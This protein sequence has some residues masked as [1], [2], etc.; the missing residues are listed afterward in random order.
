MILLQDLKQQKM[1]IGLLI[2]WRNLG[3]KMGRTHYLCLVLLMDFKWELRILSSLSRMLYQT[4]NSISFHVLLRR[5]TARS[6]TKSNMEFLD[7]WSWLGVTTRL[8][9]LISIGGLTRLI[10]MESRRAFTWRTPG[11]IGGGRWRIFLQTRCLFGTR[12]FNELCLPILQWPCLY[13]HFKTFLQE[14]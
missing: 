12:W 10:S 1:D 5:T 4:T 2:F 14:N 13:C 9:I 6:L 11:P 8:S 7:Q 3:W